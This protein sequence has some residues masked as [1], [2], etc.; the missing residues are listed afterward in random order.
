MT[1]IR[2]AEIF[3]DATIR[4]LP[5][6]T[7]RFNLKLIE[8]DSALSTPL[9]PIHGGQGRQ[10]QLSRGLRGPQNLHAPGQGVTGIELHLAPACPVMIARN[11]PVATHA[12]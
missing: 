3:P 11:K 1:P 9:E 12:R 8:G 6:V 5:T 10:Y 2:T 7:A 4:F